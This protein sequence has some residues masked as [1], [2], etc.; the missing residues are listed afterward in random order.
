MKNPLHTPFKK[1]LA[2]VLV[3]VAFFAFLQGATSEKAEV[4]TR[5]NCKIV[6]IENHK[7]SDACYED[8]R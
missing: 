7:L 2:F 4:E 6:N 8:A 1:L 5:E 3:Y